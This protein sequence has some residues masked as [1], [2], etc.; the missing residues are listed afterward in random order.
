LKNILINAYAC[1]P[2]AGSEPGMSWNWIIQLSK[3]YNIYV[4]T[5]GEWRNEIDFEINQLGLDNIHFSYIPVSEKIR[6]ICW[7][8]GNWLFYLYYY[9]WQLKAL[10]LAKN[11]CKNYN[12][13]L[14]HHLNMIGFREPGQLWKIKNIPKVWGPIG[15]FGGIP[16][17]Y[18]NFYDIKFS[19]L[20]LIKNFLSKIQLYQPNIFFAIKNYDYILIA[21]STFYNIFKKYRSNNIGL[22]N[23]SAIKSINYNS[24]NRIDNFKLLWIGRDIKSKG[25]DIAIEVFQR[26]S[27]NYL[28]E[29]HIIGVNNHSNINNKNIFFY[30]KKPHSFVQEFY[31]K[32]NLLLFTS[33]YEGTP[34][35]VLES[36]ANG[37]PVICHDKDGQSD[38]IDSNCG[39]KI[40]CI[41]HKK[42]VNDFT[43]AI[44]NLLNNNIQYENLLKGTHNKAKEFLWDKKVF[45]LMNIYNILLK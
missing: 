3:Y 18:A 25:L 35:V 30:S 22:L 42:S 38:I 6:K 27:Q 28:I 23:E 39:I 5:E 14:I 17:G 31:S 36:I 7:D 26:L 34:H 44:E 13:N 40:K 2:N 33:L 29:L 12:I 10:N 8:Q 11:I 19:I 32:C 20:I 41:N 16:T 15:G 24:I 9:F 45:D 43:A 1:R 37:L 4:I 21:N